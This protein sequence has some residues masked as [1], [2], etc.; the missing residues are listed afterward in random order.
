MRAMRCIS[1]L[2]LGLPLGCST[3]PA[4]GFPH[5]MTVG[6]VDGGIPGVADLPPLTNVVGT[7]REDSVG[8][9]FHPV[10]GAKDYRV[11]ELPAADA[12]AVNADGS[13]T[14]RNALY[15]CAGM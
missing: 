3:E 13:V 12:V 10:D 8:I 2:M 4:H 9:D 1:L 15:R 6:Q 7:L 14:I 11:Y 5:D